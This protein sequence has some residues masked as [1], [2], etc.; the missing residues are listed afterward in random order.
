MKRHYNGDSD[1]ED[2]D[3][4]TL[5]EV[6][7]GEKKIKEREKE[8]SRKEKAEIPKKDKEHCKKKAYLQVLSACQSKKGKLD[9][10]EYTNG[11]KRYE[12]DLVDNKLHGKGI[13]YDKNGVKVYEGDWLRGIRHGKGVEYYK[14]G[15]I[16]YKG[17][18][19]D[20]NFNGKGKLP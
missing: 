4:D 19:K 5:Y 12:G 20:G 1:A 9:I 10:V 15:N 11:V 2:L 14:N 8:R 17:D 13:E 18:Y 16:W 7:M 3:Y 6:L